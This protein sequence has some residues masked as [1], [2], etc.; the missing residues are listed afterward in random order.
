M[1]KQLT[2]QELADKLEALG[3]LSDNEYGAGYA[4][5]LAHAGGLVTGVYSPEVIADAHKAALDPASELYVASY[6]EG[7][8][9]Q[10]NRLALLTNA[11]LVKADGYGTD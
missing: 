2:P 5:A 4:D 3:N 8:T 6:A 1:D 7:Y 10:W 11:A 9:A